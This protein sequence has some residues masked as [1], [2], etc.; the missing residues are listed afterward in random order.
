M[1][2]RRGGGVELLDAGGGPPLGVSKELDPPAGAT[3]LEPGD[4]LVLY[5]DGIPEAFSPRHELLGLRRVAEAVER[6]EGDP[7]KTRRAVLELVDRHA[8]GRPRVDDQTLV[9]MGY[10]G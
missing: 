5:T 6:G 10:R 1:V 7:E 4:L 8:A 9:V 2:R 3:K